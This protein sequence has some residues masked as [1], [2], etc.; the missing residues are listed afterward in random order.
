MAQAL[1]CDRCGTYYVYF[2]EQNVFCDRKIKINSLSANFK[3]A[4]GTYDSDVSVDVCPR[5]RDS[6]LQ[7]WNMWQPVSE[8]NSSSSEEN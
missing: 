7:W 1:K 2:A 5:C 4:H 3:T 6:F 8:N